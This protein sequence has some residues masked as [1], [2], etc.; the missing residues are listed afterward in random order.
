MCAHPRKLRHGVRKFNE[1]FDGIIRNGTVV[2]FYCE[3]GW[4]LKGPKKKKCLDSGFWD[5]EEKV[6]CMENNS[7]KVYFNL[8]VIFLL[9]LLHTIN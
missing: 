2:E 3:K 5:P 6:K 4:M 8:C 1:T 9:I 7:V